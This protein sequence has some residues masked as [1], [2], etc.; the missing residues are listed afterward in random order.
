[1]LED[2]EAWPELHAKT[3]LP[4]IVEPT[5]ITLGK[6]VIN[7]DSSANLATILGDFPSSH[8]VVVK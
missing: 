2:L 4:K 6:D 7:I 3:I 8:N 1:V 5:S